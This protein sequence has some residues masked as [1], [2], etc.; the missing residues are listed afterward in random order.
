MAEKRFEVALPE[1]MLAGFGW[2]D[3]K[4]PARIRAAA[5]LEPLLVS[6]RRT[7]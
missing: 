7:S 5:V 3:G 6:M 4:V 1:E 2:L